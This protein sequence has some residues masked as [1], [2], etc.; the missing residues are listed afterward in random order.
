[1]GANLNDLGPELRD[2][3]YALL[4]A[5][6]AAGLQPRVTSVLRSYAEQKRLYSRF[7]AG[8]QGFPVV[9][10][11]YSAHEDRGDGFTEAFDMVVTPM[12]ALEDVGYTWNQWG[13][14]W[15]PKDAVH[16]ELPGA[17]DRAAARGRASANPVAATA[18]AINDLPWYASVFLP[19][20][21]TTERSHEADIDA[22]LCSWFGIKCGR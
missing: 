4:S 13:G 18:Q 17:T 12:D 19:I 1:V 5:A 8:Q 10:P 21:A 15:S 16:F 7:L 11:G 20:A 2:A 3:A 14:R 6:S 22:K 9:P